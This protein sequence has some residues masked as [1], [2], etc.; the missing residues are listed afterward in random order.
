LL[1][2][3]AARGEAQVLDDASGGGGGGGEAD[4]RE[5][6]AVAQSLASMNG[7]SGGFEGLGGGLDGGGG[8]QSSTLFGGS[9]FP[10]PVA[11]PPRGPAATADPAKMGQLV[12]MGFDP[13]MAADALRTSGNDLEAAVEA[14]FALM[15]D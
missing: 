14:L 8:R 1:L 13:D 4:R 11:F 6:L 9:G 12:D 5:A 3:T 15:N 10:G 2:A 7:D